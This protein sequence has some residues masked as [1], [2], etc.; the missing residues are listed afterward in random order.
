MAASLVQ[1]FLEAPS[2]DV[3]DQCRKVDLC[4]IADHYEIS[5]SRSWVKAEIKQVVLAGLVGQRVLGEGVAEPAGSS[6]QP[7]PSSRTDDKVVGEPDADAD[8]SDVKATPPATL[9]RFEPMSSLSTPSHSPSRS[10]TGANVRLKVRLARLQLEAQSKQA[11][12]DRECNLRLEIRKMELEAEVQIRRL[13]KEEKI[14]LAHVQRPSNGVSSAPVSPTSLAP[15]TDRFD[16]RK[17]ISLVPPFRESEVDSYFSV[18]ERIAITLKWPKEMWPLLLQCKL[19]GKAQEVVSA[20]SLEDSLKYDCV[21]NAVL[22][23]YEL[24]PEAYRQKFRHHKKSTN[25]TYVEFAREK[26]TL[27]DRWCSATKATDHDS[28]RELILVEEFKNSL[29]ERMVVYINEQKVLS[30]SLAAVLADEFV[31]THKTVFSTPRNENRSAE[32]HPNSQPNRSPG[33]IRNSKEKESRRWRDVI[34]LADTVL[35]PLFSSENVQVSPPVPLVGSDTESA[36]HQE[37][38]DTGLCFGSSVLSVDQWCS[39]ACL[40]SVQSEGRPRVFKLFA[41]SV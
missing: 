18:F 38:L 30:L 31:L 26:E 1:L 11:E 32:S 21:K 4:S 35:A 12:A 25:K 41:P 5:V 6:P 27:F 33:V 39:S 8:V 9:P 3:L 22:R 29:P 7:F 40:S 24:V 17:N 2:V 36:V 15:Q 19:F 13:E 16:V 34:G 20:L 37:V 10:V 14:A 28:L 23:A